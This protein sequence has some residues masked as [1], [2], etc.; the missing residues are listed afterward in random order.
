VGDAKLVT[1]GGITITGT[2]AGNY[3]LAS[4]GAMTTASITPMP[5]TAVKGVNA[6]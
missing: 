1:V 2:D 4:S 6:D 5:L 3:V